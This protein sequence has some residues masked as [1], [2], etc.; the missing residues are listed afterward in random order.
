MT[1]LSAFWTASLKLLAILAFGTWILV[2]YG[3]AREIGQ[4]FA[5]FRF[6]ESLTV[7]PQND[8][9]W[10]GPKAG[11]A[12]Y[13]RLLSANG[14]PLRQSEDLKRLV[15]ESPSGKPITYVVQRQDQI[16]SVD[17]E[18]QILDGWDFTRAFLPTLLNGL[19]HLLVGAWAFWL[20]PTRQAAAHLLLTL[21][22]GLLY[23]TLG[24]D[25]T[26]A[27]WLTPAYVAGG[28]FIAATAL[29]LALV[30]PKPLP[31]LRRHP[32]LLAFAYLPAAAFALV[33]L[34]T[35]RPI[36]H[37]LAQSELAWSPD[38]LPIWGIWTALGFAAVFARML[39]T[40]LRARDPQARS[41]ARIV[42]LGL[43]AAYL[44]GILTYVLPV[45]GK[46]T[47]SL[48]IGLISL[49]Y[50]CFILFPLSVAYAVL[51]HQLFG[52]SRALQKTLTYAA[53]T[54]SLGGLYFLLLE[55]ARAWLGLHS[56][57]A[58]LLVIFTLTV[59]FAPL[60]QR[61]QA[62]IDRL[63][64]RSPVQAQKVA[65]EFGQEAQ[66]E[67]DPARLLELFA[68]TIGGLL[69]PEVL[70]TYLRQDSHALTLT[71]SWG[72]SRD[73]PDELA[74]DHP[75][76]LQTS[77]LKQAVSVPRGTLSGHEESLC[78]PMLVQGESIGLL[79]VGKCRKGRLYEE[80]ERLFLVTMAQQLA[81]WLKNAQL[82][83]HLSRRNEELSEANRHLQELDRLKGDFLN[84]ASHELRTPLASIMGYAEFLEDGLGGPVSPEQQEY[85]QEVQRGARRLQRLVDDLLD[86]ARLEAG[87]F[88]LDPQDGDLRD[89]IAEA[90]R[91][92]VPQ[93]MALG[94]SLEL[95]L[96]DKPL[97]ARVDARRIEQVLLNLVGNALKFT[98]EHGRVTIAARSVPEG[99]RI[100][101]R[102]SGIGISP[103]QLP[104]LFEKFFQV[105]PTTTRTYGGTGLGLSIVKA[106]IDAH[107]GRVGVES[108][109]GEG[110]CFWFVLPRTPEDGRPE[111]QSAG[112]GALLRP[113][114]LIT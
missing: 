113:R 77:T 93:A 95:E 63:F 83:E 54:A 9:N 107:E 25:F 96:P 104:R 13:D 69:D 18:P 11:L 17:V 37:V 72:D 19:L 81:F 5:G 109:L 28:W 94:V 82:F 27:H 60:Y 42:L 99:C 45:A 66:A 112:S 68:S 51:R 34:L 12:S 100:E 23:Q 48:S 88:K 47:A 89:A 49:A 71:A 43:L 73:L 67:R 6:E 87:S 36:S 35:Y 58:N 101:V 3:V 114:R 15:A 39:A 74:G 14:T 41:Q 1:P 31:V 86:F 21:S 91:S 10:N 110:S 78:L 46:Q 56:Q 44:P 24:V 62:S 98:P 33:N 32:W 90:T 106:L 111:A 80:S 8:L 30:F 57:S 22:I 105:D 7:S 92:M 55:T 52:I 50:G 64:A 61:I 76:A 26:M 103:Q 84:A 20:R 79:I 53:V 4:P 97:W 59:I 75:L 102:D 2:T 16:L 108:R 65:A 38:L 70:A 29:H 85:I 40:G